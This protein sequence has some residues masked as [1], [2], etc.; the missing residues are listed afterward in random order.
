MQD[1]AP[2]WDALIGAVD[3]EVEPK[4]LNAW[5]FLTNL[6][7]GI[8]IAEDLS[9]LKGSPLHQWFD[10]V[11]NAV[12]PL[13]FAEAIGVE[14]SN[15]DRYVGSKV[16][17]NLLIALCLKLEAIAWSKRSVAEG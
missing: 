7:E 17:E 12:H 5:L 8:A 1:S 16:A 2:D 10:E 15:V 3:Y 13:E 6:L 14:L 4:P 11:A 9:R